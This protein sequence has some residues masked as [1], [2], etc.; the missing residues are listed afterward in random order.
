M[1][2][3]NITNGSANVCDKRNLTTWELEIVK[4]AILLCCED[5]WNSWSAQPTFLTHEI[6]YTTFCVSMT[7]F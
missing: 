6:I 5:V 7:S 4:Q 1:N 3:N 2:G